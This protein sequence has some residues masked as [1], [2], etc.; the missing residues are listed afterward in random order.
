MERTDRIKEL[1]ELPLVTESPR[2]KVLEIF[3]DLCI[4]K[5]D[6]QRYFL[7]QE[8]YEAIK[9][10]M[11]GQTDTNNERCRVLLRPSGTE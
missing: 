11:E 2:Q 5:R 9:E 6:T 4:A 1:A 7:I 10:D 3:E 8:V